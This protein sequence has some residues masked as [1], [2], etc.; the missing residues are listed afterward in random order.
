MV[1]LSRALFSGLCGIVAAGLVLCDRAALAQTTLAEPFIRFTFED[2]TSPPLKSEGASEPQFMTGFKGKA[3]VIGDPSQVTYWDGTDSPFNWERGT[4]SFWYMPIDWKERVRVRYWV[5]T[6]REAGKGYL[7][8]V[9]T[10]GSETTP[11]VLCLQMY[12]TENQPTHLW[13]AVESWINGRWY[14]VTVTWEDSAAALYLNGKL[15]S[16]SPAFSILR[17]TSMTREISGNRLYFGRNL[18]WETYP[19]VERSLLDEVEL[20]AEPLDADQVRR[21]HYQQRPRVSSGD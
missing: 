3:M 16:N 8:I 13:N 4:L 20:R 2:A 7:R 11:A 14:F 12:N 9:H 18:K 5:S 15:D 17:Q 6:D 21:L 19:T 10:A 1:G